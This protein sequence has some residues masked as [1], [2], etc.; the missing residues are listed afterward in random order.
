[1]ITDRRDTQGAAGLYATFLA[2]YCSYESMA[3]LLQIGLACQTTVELAVL[4]LE[5][6][7]DLEE[8]YEVLTQLIASNLTTSNTTRTTSAVNWARLRCD[9]AEERGLVAVTYLSGEDKEK[10]RARHYFLT[11]AGEKEFDRLQ[12]EFDLAYLKPKESIIGLG[13]I[14]RD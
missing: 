8:P 4:R 11:H 2:I 3:P 1:M 13:L 7:E 12:A 10:K 5:K 6:G 9:R 14:R